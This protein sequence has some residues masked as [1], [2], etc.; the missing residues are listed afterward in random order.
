M[1]TKTSELI[2]ALK[3]ELM[4]ALDA[5]VKPLEERLN[6][7]V[8]A[9]GPD[10]ALTSVV[11]SDL[12]ARVIKELGESDPVPLQ[13]REEVDKV[14]SKEFGIHMRY[15]GEGFHFTI[16][17]PDKYSSRTPEEKALGVPDL[18]LKVIEHGLGVNGV[19]EWI[20]LV[21]KNFGPEVQALITADRLQSVV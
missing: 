16:V 1:P 10:R 13:Y 6:G 21:Y 2:E 19:K 15:A 14:F 8:P 18:R 20:D 9:K 5:R 4:E 17:V 11:K 7:L 3:V 12:S